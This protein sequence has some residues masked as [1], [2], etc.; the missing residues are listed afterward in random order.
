MII[1]YDETKFERSSPRGRIRLMRE[2]ADGRLEVTETFAEEMSYC[3]GCLACQTA[4]PAGVDYAILVGE[5][6]DALAKALGPKVK[7]AHVPATA[8]AIALVQDE[9]GPG[10]AIL[11][12]GSNSIGLAALVEEQQDA[13]EPLRFFTPLSVGQRQKRRAVGGDTIARKKHRLAVCV[14]RIG[15]AVGEEVLRTLLPQRLVQPF[16]Q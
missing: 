11:V 16:D 1:A 5:E 2:V 15:A 9:L 7:M 12:K 14:R 3:L 6:M 4:C 8:A 13:L 10:D